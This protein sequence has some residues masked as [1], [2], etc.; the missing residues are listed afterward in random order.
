MVISKKVLKAAPKRNQ[1]RRRVY[2]IVRH[3]WPHVK[4]SHDLLISIYDP[5]FLHLSHEEVEAEVIRALKMA[6]IWTESAPDTTKSS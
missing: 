1:V 3:N 5:Q 6:H 2:E 4:G